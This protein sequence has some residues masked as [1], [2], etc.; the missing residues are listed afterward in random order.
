MGGRRRLIAFLV[1]LGISALALWVLVSSVDLPATGA[2]LRRARIEGL[3]PI[4]IVLAIQFSLR[5]FRWS[6]LAASLRP[7]APVPASHFAAP[8]AMGYL[9]NA[10]LPARLGEAIR[11]AVLGRAEGLPVAAVLGTV[12]VERILDTLTL[13]ALAGVV[14][15]AIAPEWMARLAAGVAVIAMVVLGVLV[16]GGG[17]AATKLRAAQRG[18]LRRAATIGGGAGL[19]IASAVAGIPRSALAL[20]VAI[21]LAAWLGDALLFWLV[22]SAL[23]I[24]LSLGA[25]F[26]VAAVTV[27]GT[28]VPSSP[29]YIGTFEAAAVAAAAALGVPSGDA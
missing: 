4:A 15:A 2:A 9:G 26:L 8:L 7:D 3:A 25:A 5:T 29:G 22:A 1:G 17:I 11:A 16:V 10:V 27:L 18:P 6:R 13:A 20:A 14:A 21:S 24:G 23:G 12:L 28:A 19:T